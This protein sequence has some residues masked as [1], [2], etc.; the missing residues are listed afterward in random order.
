MYMH[1]FKCT[2]TWYM[3]IHS[4]VN[5]CALAYVLVIE[6]SCFFVIRGRELCAGVYVS[7]CVNISRTA[8][9][10]VSRLK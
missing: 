5:A 3:Y 9:T 2:C 10:A 7:V 1:V 4:H 6:L 8:V